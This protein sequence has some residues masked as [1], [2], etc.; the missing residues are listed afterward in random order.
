MSSIDYGLLAAQY[1]VVR[2]P[3]IRIGRAVIEALARSVVNVGAGTGSY[4][5]S[6]RP[7]VAVEP[8][9]AMIAT[10]RSGTAPAI[11]GRAES[12]PFTDGA[13]D[14]AMAILTVHHWQDQ[15]RG[16][17][18]LCRVA[19]RRVVLT[20]DPDFSDAFWL[21]RD[22]LPESAEIDRTWFRPIREV[23][24]AIGGAETRVVP[25]PHDCTDGFLCAYWR[26]PE[27][28]LDPRV[29]AGISTFARLDATVVAR[30]LGALERDLDSGAFWDRHADLVER[31]A[32]DLG[33]RLIVAG[34]GARC[35][36]TPPH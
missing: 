21:V 7:V 34:T 18:E 12:L 15:A 23:V 4:E 25:I 13:F 31:D 17:A 3:D 29:R 11:Q 30:T 28:Y 5:P 35:D 26:R 16:L 9:A 19:R 36:G 32:V 27:A 20:F 6:D 22:Y 33:Y 2:R 1:S 24:E 10:R 8:S 14:A